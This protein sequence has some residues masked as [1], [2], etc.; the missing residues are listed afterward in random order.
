MFG[1]GFLDDFNQKNVISDPVNTQRGSYN[2]AID[3]TR[4]LQ[5]ELPVM[6]LDP[7]VIEMEWQNMAE[8]IHIL[9]KSP[10]DPIH[11]LDEAPAP[12]AVSLKNEVVG[13]LSY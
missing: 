5:P 7:D 6:A 9:D 12:T 4:T 3:L 2:E 10:I 13:V 11:I 1:V 8:P